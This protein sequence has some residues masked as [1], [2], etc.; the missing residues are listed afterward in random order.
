VVADGRHEDWRDAVR[1]ARA[2]ALRRGVAILW[3]RLEIDDAER[4]ATL[5]LAESLPAPDPDPDADAAPANGNGR[6]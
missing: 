4:Q 1:L 2:R 3:D 6:A 5:A